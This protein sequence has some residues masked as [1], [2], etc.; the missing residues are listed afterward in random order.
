MSWT[1]TLGTDGYEMHMNSPIPGLP[2]IAVAA[3]AATAFAMSSLRA[4]PGMVTVRPLPAPAAR[5]GARAQLEELVRYVRLYVLQNG[6]MPTALEDLVKAGF[7][8]D[9]PNDPWGRPIR[10]VVLDAGQRDFRVVSHG[11]D[12]QEQSADDLSAGGR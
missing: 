10:L 9:V 2:L 3:V 1:E 6:A 8:E 12:G 7:L 4:P 11:P 5:G